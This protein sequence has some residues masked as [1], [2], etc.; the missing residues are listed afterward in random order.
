MLGVL[1]VQAKFPKYSDA[2]L[3]EGIFIGPQIREIINDDDL[4]GHLITVYIYTYI[5]ILQLVSGFT[6]YVSLS[7]CRLRHNFS[8][9]KIPQ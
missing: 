7:V 4:S 8:E 9:T 6:Y 2:K 3:K 5:Y 1:N